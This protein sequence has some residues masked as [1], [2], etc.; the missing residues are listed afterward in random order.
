LLKMR[1]ITYI[2]FL[3][4]ALIYMSCDDY[5]ITSK[6]KESF[7][8]FYGGPSL[9]YGADVKQNSDGSY[10]ILGTISTPDKGTDMCLILTDEYGNTLPNS[11]TRYYGGDYNDK[12]V[13][14]RVLDNDDLVLMG[15]YQDSITGDMNIF[16][17]KTNSSGE[18]LWT[19]IIEDPEKPGNQEAYDLQ[20]TGS[21]DLLIVGYYENNNQKDIYQLLLNSDGDIS[22][23]P[24]TIGFTDNDD[25]GHSIQIVSDG[26][27]IVGNT[28]SR[29][30]G[31]TRYRSFIIK[32]DLYGLIN[33]E[34]KT[35]FETELDYINFIRVLPDNDYLVSGTLVNND[36]SNIYMVKLDNQTREIIWEKTF[37]D[38]PD[39]YC[40]GLQI[41]NNEIL[42]LG[43][44]RTTGSTSNIVFIKTDLDGNILNLS[45]YGLSGQM[46][47]LGFD[48]TEDNGYIFTGSSTTG[49]NSVITLIKT[50]NNGE[51]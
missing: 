21:G 25:I 30:V 27:I 16:L 49:D 15:S 4:F 20:V 36:V 28:K 34:F 29:P 33:S 17:V 7:V 31:S 46:E 39:S 19:K 38:L 5:K 50:R 35:L 10:A 23:D 44:R 43:T 18:L 13:C 41:D 8:K 11:T 42:I 51:F 26:Y 32:T 48:I 47:G 12:G 24:K 45:E 14:L 40:T 6:Q 2:I 3:L 9:D 1:S 37:T 22:W